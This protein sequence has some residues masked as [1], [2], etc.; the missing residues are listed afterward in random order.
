MSSDCVLAERVGATL[1]VSINR[2]EQRN[3]VDAEVSL[4]IGTALDEADQDS[5]V[6]VVVLTGVGD[7]AFCAGADLKALARGEPILAVERPEWGFAGFVRHVISKPT[8]IAVNG[9]ALAGGTE[10]VLAGDIAV[11]SQEATFGLPEVRRGII[12]AAGG[13]VRLPRQLPAKIATELA[14]TGDPIGAEAAAR[15]GLVNRVVPPDQV[16]PEALA[17]ADRIATNAPLAVQA[18]KRVLMR[19]NGQQRVDEVDSWAANDA[20]LDAIMLTQDA[21]EGPAAFA[22]KRSPSWTGT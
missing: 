3:A 15:W 5:D 22:E 20:E 9:V 18:S 10:I 16:L 1:L 21:R 4:R 17:L 19:I 14:L 2:P 11:A 6:R 12:A 13:L 7:R 8:I